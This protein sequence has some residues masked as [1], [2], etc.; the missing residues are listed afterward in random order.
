MLQHL[1][2]TGPRRS[3]APAAEKGDAG[4]AMPPDPRTPARG[5]LRRM[6]TGGKAV[7][8]RLENRFLLCWQPVKR[9]S[10]LATVAIR[11]GRR[12]REGQGLRI[13]LERK[14][15]ARAEK[16]RGALKRRAV[17]RSDRKRSAPEADAG[18][19]SEPAR[20]GGRASDRRARERVRVFAIDDISPFLI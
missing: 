18:G 2:M 16:G 5:A 12:D 3:R 7:L 1:A 14:S 9:N 4:E 19:F 20:A 13:G 15:E 11:T 17:H 8:L 6:Q 10:E